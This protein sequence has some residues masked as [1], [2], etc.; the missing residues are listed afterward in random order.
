VVAIRAV[1]VLTV[2]AVAPGA[3]H[4]D[5]AATTDTAAAVDQSTRPPSSGLRPT[6][7]CIDQ[8]LA[9]RLAIKRKRRKVV[10]RLFVKQGRHELSATGG[11]YVSDLF[12][13][14]WVAGGAYTFHM[15]DATA[16]ELGFAYT[17]EDADAVRALEDGRA[18]LID[19]SYAPMRLIESLLVL[20]PIYGKLRLGGTVARFDLHT[21]VGVGVVDSQTSR[22]ASGVAG[23][24][25]KLFVGD[26]VA[27]RLD[28]RDRVF[29][30][31]LLDEQFLVNDLSL[32]LG[33]SVFVP[34]R[35]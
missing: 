11:Y 15:T 30:Q 24:G 14:T 22:G 16:V 13:S 34:V 28:A 7:A 19:D 6:A 9:D 29:R 25:M 21:D 17:H 3:A 1:I 5:A 4:A 26:A 20:T 2:L 12:S 18:T 31:E 8:E 10:D 32:T 35:N 23:L 27:I 33:L